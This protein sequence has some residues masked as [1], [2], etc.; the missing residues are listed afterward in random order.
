MAGNIDSNNSKK[1]CTSGVDDVLGGRD[2][3]SLSSD[4]NDNVRAGGGLGAIDG[5]F[6]VDG[7]L[8]SEGGGESLDLSNGSSKKRCSRVNDG[9]LD[10]SDALSVDGDGV[11]VDLPVGGR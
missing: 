11:S 2:G 4:G 7:S 9:G 8:G 10:G 3:V 1:A 6:V 5:V